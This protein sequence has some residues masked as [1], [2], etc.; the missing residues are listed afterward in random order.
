[1]SAELDQEMQKLPKKDLEYGLSVLEALLVQI[2]ESLTSQ[3]LTEIFAAREKL[4]G[5]LDK[6]IS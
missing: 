4:Q 6:K 3:E 5:F 2:G 1:M